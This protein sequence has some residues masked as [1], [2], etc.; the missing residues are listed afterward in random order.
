MKTDLKILILAMCLV[1]SCSEDEGP[2]YSIKPAEI[3][4][5]DV[6]NAGLVNE[7]IAIHVRTTGYNGCWSKLKVVLQQED[8]RHFLLKA[9][10][11]VAASNVCPLNLVQKDTII[12]FTPTHTGKYYFRANLEPLTILRDTLNVE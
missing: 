9:T 12:S 2:N 6:D 3:I 11:R 10:G 5:L 7:D 4:F 1:L 8:D